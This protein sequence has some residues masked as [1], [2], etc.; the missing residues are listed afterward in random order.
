MSAS[1]YSEQPGQ[2]EPGHH[3]TERPLVS[4]FQPQRRDLTAE[5]G[6]RS[7]ISD[8]PASGSL[9]FLN[10]F[11]CVPFSFSSQQEIERMFL[12]GVGI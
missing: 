9:V 5:G 7:A 10:G 2:L 12:V 3:E 8:R 6:G 1:K 11:E 4:N